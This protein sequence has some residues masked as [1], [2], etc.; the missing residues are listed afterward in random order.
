[1][2]YTCQE[3]K[4]FNTINMQFTLFI[5]FTQNCGYFFFYRP[6]KCVM[7]T[8]MAHDLVKMPNEDQ[9]R[10]TVNHSEST[11]HAPQIGHWRQIV[12]PYK[13]MRT[14]GQIAITRLR[15]LHYMPV[16]FD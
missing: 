6:Q 1:M 10:E 4:L 3:V 7:L 9:A 11:F 16:Y 5:L 15:Y 12:H 2:I 8:P 13:H 14:L